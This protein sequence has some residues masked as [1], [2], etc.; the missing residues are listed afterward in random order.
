MRL[1]WPHPQPGRS[2]FAPTPNRGAVGLT[3][4]PPAGIKRPNPHTQA[5]AQRP[6]LSFAPTNKPDP[7][8]AT[9]TGPVFVV[10]TS[11]EQALM[12]R[13]CQHLYVVM[14]LL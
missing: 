9:T 1:Q 6:A 14:Q 12:I 4:H 10:T 3:P 8:T 7:V 2:A 13:L 5:R 11:N